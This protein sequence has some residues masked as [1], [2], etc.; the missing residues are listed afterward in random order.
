MQK[1]T[2][3]PELLFAK[4]CSFFFFSESNQNRLQHSEYSC[5]EMIQ[6]SSGSHNDKSANGLSF[7][8]KLYFFSND[9]NGG[10]LPQF[11]DD[12]YYVLDTSIHTIKL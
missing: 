9:E 1:N 4:N 7:S 11:F 12:M 8:I 3:H 2:A 5:L 10:S 6:T